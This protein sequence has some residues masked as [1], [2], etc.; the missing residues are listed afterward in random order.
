MAETGP[1]VHTAAGHTII[2]TIHIT[3]HGE[4]HIRI[5]GTKMGGRF[6]SHQ[7]ERI[8]VHINLGERLFIHSTTLTIP[9]QDHGLH[10]DTIQP[11]RALESLPSSI[12]RVVITE[13]LQSEL[14]DE[15]SYILSGEGH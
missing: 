8:T 15:K 9:D 3:A 2:S 4:S 1:R 10:S 13:V 11:L 7:C 12:S 5:N 14:Y 6:H